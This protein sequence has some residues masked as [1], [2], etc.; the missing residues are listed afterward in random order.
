[1]PVEIRETPVGGKLHDFLNVVDYVYR[2]DPY[3]VRPLDIE[4]K[5]RFSLKNPFF[6][7]ADGATFTAFRNGWC[8]GRVSAQ[9]DREHLARHQ[10]DIGSFGFLDTIDD[11][12]VA[13][14][15]LDAACRWL[16]ARGM[17]RV[18]GPLSLGL[19]EEVGCQVQG[20]ATAPM[21]MAPHHRPYQG[22]LIEQAGFTKLKDYYSVRLSAASGI[23]RAVSLASELE[24][25]TSIKA[26]HIDVRSLDAELL[27]CA[28]VLND[29]GSEQWGF[30]PWTDRERSKLAADLKLVAVPELTFLVE[31][32]GQASG[33]AFAVP[34]LYELISDLNGSL[35]P[36]GLPKLLWRLKV[37]GAKTCA[38]TT[39]GVKRELPPASGAD[40]QTYLL[41]KLV[42]GCQRLALESI[43][44]V[45]AEDDHRMAQAAA[46]LGGE[47]CRTARLY[48][49]PL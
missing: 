12:E 35:L 27:L 15:L 34:N 25:R 48:E 19:K 39:L 40:L 1:M 28:E 29:G 11:E 24:A 16:R 44:L 14:A 26:R 41:A 49:K 6:E 23:E 4:L 10:D 8:V 13:R 36:A 21:L 7:H 30:V 43:Q 20:F 37:A 42:T 46:A 45:H 33:V 17:R 5:A 18:R 47:Q 38:L 9:V 2:G 3:Y 32:E 22:G 31:V